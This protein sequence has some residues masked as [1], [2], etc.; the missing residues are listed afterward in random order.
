MFH[1]SE[2]EIEPNTSAELK[3]DQKRARAVIYVETPKRG[4]MQLAFL[5]AAE[6][7]ARIDAS[8]KFEG[9]LHRCSAPDVSATWKGA[10]VA[11]ESTA[12]FN[13]AELNS[14][15]DAVS[16]ATGLEVKA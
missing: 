5:I 14:I 2:V 3:V 1:K 4:A 9:R 6:L 11:I 13:A 7:A 12:A 16:T 15:R 10:Q 8:A